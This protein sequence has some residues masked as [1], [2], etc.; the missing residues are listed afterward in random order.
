MFKGQ[1][2]LAECPR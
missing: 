1:R 2:R